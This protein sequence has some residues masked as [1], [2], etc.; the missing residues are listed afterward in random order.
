MREIPIQRDRVLAFGNFLYRSHAITLICDFRKTIRLQNFVVHTT[1]DFLAVLGAD[2]V[3][4]GQRSRLNHDS[5]RSVI[6]GAGDELHFTLKVRY[7]N[8][9]IMTKRRKQSSSKCPDYERT[10][11][12]VN[13]V[14]NFRGLRRLCCSQ[15]DTLP[16]TDGRTWILARRFY[17]ARNFR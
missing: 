13:H 8:R 1:L 5:Q 14:S 2:V 16:W 15:I 4:H 17:I 12:G 9:R 11:L 7:G 6:Q 3:G 10:S